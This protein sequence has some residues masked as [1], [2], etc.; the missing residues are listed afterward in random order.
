MMEN[1]ISAIESLLFFWGDPLDYDSIE[2]ILE[3]NKNTLNQLIEQLEEKYK[4]ESS[5]IELKII[6][7]SIQLVTKAKNSD[8][9]KKLTTKID[10]KTLSN[11]LMETL[12][13]IAYKQPIT[14]VEIDNVRGVNSSS[15]INTLVNRNLV[16]ELGK[17]DQI[18]KPIIYGTT[19]EF[20]RVFALETLEDLP[21]E[22]DFEEISIKDE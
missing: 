11:S 4:D 6:N 2:K 16:E 3:I 8:Y 19:D 5:G 18:G 1:K 17:L 13:I 12:S 20:L 14:R 9:I 7:D 10:N 22:N 15:S 21:S